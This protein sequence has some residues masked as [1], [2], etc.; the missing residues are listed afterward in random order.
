MIVQVHACRVNDVT[1]HLLHLYCVIR[2][3]LVLRVHPTLMCTCCLPNPC[4]SLSI[5]PI[6]GHLVLLGYLLA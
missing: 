6:G 5:L 3:I 4:R 2:W 1:A